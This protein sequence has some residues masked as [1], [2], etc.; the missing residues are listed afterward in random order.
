ML[1]QFKKDLDSD[2]VEYFIGIAK[3][4]PF[5][6]TSP[7]DIKSIHY[8]SEMRHTLQSVKTLSSNSFVV[9]LI[10][11]TPNII[12]Q[13]YDDGLTLGATDQVTQFYVLNSLNEVFICIQQKKLA[14]GQSVISTVEPTSSLSLPGSPGR[15]FKTSDDYYWRQI[16][17]LSNLAIYS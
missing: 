4:T 13:E 2:G 1:D 10:N 16:G 15:T 14:G 9:P 17:V 5:S 8:Q 11:W 12:W 3:N 7:L 6:L